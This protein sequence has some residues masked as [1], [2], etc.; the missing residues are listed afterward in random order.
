MNARHRRI[1]LEVCSLPTAPFVETAVQLYVR[2]FV[3]ARKGLSLSADRW[4][5]LMVT[6]ARG[7]RPAAGPLWLM[8]HMDHPGFVAD[9][10]LGPSRLRARWFGGVAVECFRDAKVRFFLPDG[11][12]GVAATVRGRVR[13]ILTT[14]ERP[15][16]R[17]NLRKR[18][19]AV[20]LEVSGPVPA[21]TPGMWDLPDAAI[22]NGRLYARGVDDLGEV[23]AMLCLL[24]DLHRE[25]SPGHV[26]CA[27]TRAEE[28]GFV[29][30]IGMAR[31]KTIPAGATVISLEC[32]SAAAAGVKLGDGPILRVG[33]IATTFDPRTSLW[34][35]KVAAD[36][37]RTRRGFTYQRRLMPGGACEATGVGAYGYTVAAM[38]V[39]LGNY[40]NMTPHSRI[41]AESI[42]VGDFDK[43]V[44][45]LT[46]LVRQ[47]DRRVGIEAGRRERMEQTFAG[48][49]DL[50]GRWQSASA[51]ITSPLA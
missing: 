36:L 9:G 30:A 23:A 51:A 24:D 38:C 40:H 21:G 26:T 28:V 50:L 17:A 25:G 18:P 8:A 48:H 19:E 34:I 16:T 1:L 12:G 49:R 39:G 15:G 43:L 41:G 6:Y 37:A 45:W 5:N 29:G 27:F 42:D 13:R 31:E 44:A 14:V 4:G 2:R 11:Q 47:A 32:S 33:D 22:R 10:M 3:A 20:E 35:E 46:A 7:R